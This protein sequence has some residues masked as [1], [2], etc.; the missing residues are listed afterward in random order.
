MTIVRFQPALARFP[1]SHKI[2]IARAIRSSNG[3]SHLPQSACRLAHETGALLHQ[4]RLRALNQMSGSTVLN[5][6]KV[7]PYRYPK[8]SRIRARCESSSHTCAGDERR[9]PPTR[10]AIVNS[11][12]MLFCSTWMR[13]NVASSNTYTFLVDGRCNRSASRCHDAASRASPSASRPI[14]STRPLRLDEPNDAR[15]A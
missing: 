15:D 4:N 9:G 5:K 1:D 6:I 3:K 7:S 11:L 12:M 13:P 8:P 10:V 14:Y 2:R